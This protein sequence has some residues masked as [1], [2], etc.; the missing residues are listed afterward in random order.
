MVGY[1][2]LVID[3]GRTN[4][5]MISTRTGPRSGK[6]GVDV[7]VRL[8][9]SKAHAMAASADRVASG[10]NTWPLRVIRGRPLAVGS[11]QTVKLNL[12]EVVLS[13]MRA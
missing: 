1:F 3:F 2:R 11:I 6:H 9:F 12:M 10:V 13:T 4:C 8:A 7:E 5:A